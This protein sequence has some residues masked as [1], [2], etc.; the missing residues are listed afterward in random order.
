MEQR[1]LGSTGIELS[2]LGFGAATLGDIYGGIDPDEGLRAVRHAIDRGINFFDVAPYYGQTLAETRLGEALDGLRDRVV[3]SSKCCRYGFREFDFSRKSVADSLEASLQRLRTDHLDLFI[4]HDIEFGDRS[5]VEQEA[6]PAALE[7]KAAGKVRAVGI[8]GLPIHHLRNVAGATGVDF[9][10]SYCHYNLLVDDLDRVLVPH[11]ATSGIGLINASPLHM[12]ILSAEGPPEWHPASDHIKETG[13]K[14]IELCDA[15][16]ANVSQVSL[17]LALDHPTLTSTL[18][19]MKTRAQV[20][21]NLEILGL[22][23]DPSLLQ[24]IAE[25]VEPVKNLTWPEGLPENNP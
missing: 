16:G 14:V 8:S 23:N 9:V 11:A 17:R 12:G 1:T 20:D 19:G 3:L 15:R 21:Q 22:Q 2:V 4:I 10:L 6:V 25:L 5:Q 13:R 18:C 7:A 24:E